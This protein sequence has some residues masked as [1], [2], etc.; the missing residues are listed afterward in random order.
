MRGQSRVTLDWIK[1][2]WISSNVQRPVRGEGDEGQGE[3]MSQGLRE[4]PGV[5]HLT[6]LLARAPPTRGAT[7][8]FSSLGEDDVIGIL[9]E[10]EDQLQCCD[11]RVHQQQCAGIYSIK[12]RD[13]TK[14]THRHSNDAL[15]PAA[16]PPRAITISVVA[17][18]GTEGGSSVT[19]RIHTVPVPY[20][21]SRE[22]Q[23]LSFGLSGSSIDCGGRNQ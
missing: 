14:G 6:F 11:L 5:D 4:A 17:G 15:V 20:S 18:T 10:A 12:V 21:I 3:L 22:N 7:R 8:Y 19:S 1:K 13:L 16:A 23:I 2:K 9:R